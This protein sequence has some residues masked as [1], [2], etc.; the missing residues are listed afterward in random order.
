MSMPRN[1]FWLWRESFRRFNH[2][3]IQGQ[4]NLLDETIIAPFQVIR[5]HNSEIITKRNQSLVKRPIM[6]C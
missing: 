3:T 6:D 5:N 4:K 1:E 2:L